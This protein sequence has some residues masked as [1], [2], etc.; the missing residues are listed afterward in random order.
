MEVLVNPESVGAV[1][2]GPHHLVQTAMT[3]ED[4]TALPPSTSSVGPYILGITT[5][6]GPY[7][8]PVEMLVSHER[9]FEANTGSF[10]ESCNGH[11]PCGEKK[12]LARCR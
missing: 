1:C 10:L 4:G 12:L 8:T 5:S 11:E 6:S 2:F 3:L 7:L 9:K